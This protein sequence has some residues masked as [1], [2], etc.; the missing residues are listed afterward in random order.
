MRHMRPLNKKAARIDKYV[1]SKKDDIQ[2]WDG[3]EACLGKFVA[4]VSGLIRRMAR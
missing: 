1:V 3:G 2:P 4:Q